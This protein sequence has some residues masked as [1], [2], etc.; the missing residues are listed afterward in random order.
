MELKAVIFDLDGVVTD[1]VPLHYKAWK[2]LF[3]ELG[4]DFSPEIYRKHVDGIPR[5]DGIRNMLPGTDSGRLEKLAGRKQRYYLDQLEKT[6]PEVFND[7]LSLM[8]EL[9]LHNVKI[10]VASSSKNC[11]DI[12]KKL[13]IYDLD[14]VVSGND[15][16]KGKPAPEI[17][18]K[19]AALLGIS[20]ANCLVIEDAILGVKAA[21]AAGMKCVMLC[22][23][24]EESDFNEYDIKLRNLEITYHKLVSKL[25]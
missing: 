9:R 20:P 25:Y 7:A 10:A 16:E 2:K 8:K 18:L 19:A 17:F 3:D 12:L 22:R 4:V 14:A 11:R 1:T 24:Q 23:G 5:I 15:F 21:K 6:P 13:A